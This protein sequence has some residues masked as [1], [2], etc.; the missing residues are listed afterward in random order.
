MQT[1]TPVTRPQGGALP[2][3]KLSPSDFA[4][5]WEECPRCFYAKVAQG[6]PRPFGPFPKIFNNID[7]AMKAHY[8]D[9]RL[10]LAPGL[11]PGVIRFSDEWV[12][13]APIALPGRSMTCTIRG[14]FDSVIE[15]D[16]GT[17]GVLDFKTADVR[18]PHVALYARQLHAYALA[19][20]QA[21]AGEFSVG[22]ISRLGLLV[23]QPAY[24]SLGRRNVATLGGNL[25]W[26]EIPRDD[27]AFLGFLHQ[28]VGLL[29]QPT[30]PAGAANCSWCR[31]RAESRRR[32]L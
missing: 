5:L 7:A 22:P 11:P 14:R 31:Y 30:P 29:E 2:N 4:F 10:R 28:V 32:A 1:A 17:Y 12:G 18:D 21:A 25:A 3:V 26:L 6:F 23:F 19:L 15:F 8:N 24:F 20:E 16:N 27:A 9:R 13:S